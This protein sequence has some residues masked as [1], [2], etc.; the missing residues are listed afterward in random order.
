M[1]VNV[2]GLLKSKNEIRFL[3]DRRNRINLA[4]EMLE[5]SFETHFS[6]KVNHLYGPKFQRNLDHLEMLLELSLMLAN[7]LPDITLRI[8]RNELLPEGVLKE[9]DVSYKSIRA[10][11]SDGAVK[12]AIETLHS[13]AESD[14]IRA[15]CN[16]LKHRQLI[17]VKTT[18]NSS[19]FYGPVLQSFVYDG[20]EFQERKWTEV[21]SAIDDSYSR[22]VEVVAAISNSVRTL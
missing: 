9:R 3:D 12:E 20:K 13:S 4:R 1:D 2:E 11:L 15:A 5:D 14:Y 6:A 7:S 21:F 16:T 10:N 8:A 22:V 18:L 19:G 17:R